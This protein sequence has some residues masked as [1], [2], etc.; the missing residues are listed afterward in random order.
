MDILCT[1]KTGT[2]TEDLLVFS[3][4]FDA[5]GAPNDEALKA[6][7]LNSTFQTGLKNFL[8][9]A[10]IQQV[11]P[12]KLN[13]FVEG[14]RLIDEI[15]F[16]FSRKRMSVLVEDRDNS[17]RLIC[18]GAVEEVLSLCH[19]GEDEV[20]KASYVAA[21]KQMNDRGF[22]ILAVAQRA[23]NSE[24][25]SCEL[26]DE[27]DLQFLGYI[28]F[29]D[30]PAK[31][32]AASAIRGLSRYG[33]T[34]KILTGDNE[35]VTEKIAK[36]VGLQVTGV[37]LGPQI[38][39]MS[40]SELRESVEKVNVFAKLTPDQKEK[41]INAFHDGGH[42]VGFI[43]DGIND[44]PALRA[45]DVGISVN[46]AVDIAKESADI[47]LLEKSL[48]VLEQ[49]VIEGR[50]VFGNIIKYIKMGASSN[51]G[52]VFSMLGASSL[53]PFLPLRPVQ[54]LTQNL[55][56]D[57]SQVGIPLDQVDAEYLERPRR[58]EI[59]DIQRFML[60]M[61]PVS[62]IFDYATFALMWFY[63]KANHL[64]AQSL[65][66]TGWFVEG[67][68]SQTLI[69]HMIRTRKI[70]FLQSRAS[71]ALLLTTTMVM[72]IG[73]YLPFSRLGRV[74]GFVALP[75]AYF[76]WLFAILILYCVL[77]QLVKNWFIKR[78]GYN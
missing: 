1:D 39:S 47:I 72:G 10:L 30:P 68:L 50:K 75:G 24:Q 55:L 13:S 6:A 27:R 48:L 15:P 8:D 60:F 42:V 64:E 16:D 21:A 18:K 77:S 76:P 4:A 12:G 20:K 65:F 26:S 44:A 69:V 52:N 37:L 59:G 35:R 9:L 41:I 46:N 31:E 36:D 58:W 43:G 17:R 63:F 67:L 71:G 3:G 19:A 78:Y 11:E 2:L 38:E 51:F 56:Y 57:F 45:A 74:L 33:V 53:L 29:L 14:H 49:G 5:H 73:I 7:C 62:S 22:R 61:G 70:P 23:L 54:M 40:R 32:T 25:Q 28:A 66:Q 34:V